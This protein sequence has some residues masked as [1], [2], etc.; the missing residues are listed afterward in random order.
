M[1]ELS[2]VRNETPGIYAVDAAAQSL[3]ARGV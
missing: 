2:A 3:R 1:K